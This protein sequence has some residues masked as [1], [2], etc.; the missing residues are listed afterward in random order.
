MK[1][2]CFLVSIRPIALVS[3][4][5]AIFLLRLECGWNPNIRL[6]DKLRYDARHTVVTSSLAEFVE[7]VL[8][9]FSPRQVFESFLSKHVKRVSNLILDSLLPP[10]GISCNIDKIQ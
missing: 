4:L 7:S 10:T 8:S 6:I 5:L 1:L 9:V 3:Y 2:E